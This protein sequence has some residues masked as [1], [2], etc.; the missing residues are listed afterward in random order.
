ML[1]RIKKRCGIAEQ[2]TVY[3]DDIQAYIED[4]LQDLRD[5]GVDDSLIQAQDCR[6]L[7]AVTFYVKANLG[8]DRSDT[9]TYMRLYRNKVFRLT[10]ADPVQEVERVE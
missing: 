4:C 7:T 3:D 10:L 5:S 9:N 6:V 1:E 2:V 8:D